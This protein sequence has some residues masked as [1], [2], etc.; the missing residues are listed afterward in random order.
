MYCMGRKYLSLQQ[1]EKRACRKCQICG[2]D[3]YDLL[4]AHRILEGAN[5]GKYTQSNILVT[6]SQCHRKIH[7]GRIEILGKHFSTS[8]SYVIHFLE[9]GVEKWV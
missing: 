4:D 9:D 8:G 1:R 2:E 3:D 6:C 5:G 7:S